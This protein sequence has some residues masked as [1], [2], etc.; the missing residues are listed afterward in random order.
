VRLPC[1]FGTWLDPLF[2]FGSEAIERG[3]AVRNRTGTGSTANGRRG[4]SRRE[5]L[6]S[7]TGAGLS[8]AGANAIAGNEVA[9]ATASPTSKSILRSAMQDGGRIVY[10]T[11][12]GSWEEA[13][14]KAW[15]D[16]FTEQTGIEVVT[17]TGPDYGK[18]R[19]MVEA[20]NTEWDVAEVNPDFQTIGRRENLLETLSP[21]LIPAEDA[22]DPKIL[23]D[24]SVPQVSWA[25]V[26]TYN[27]NAFPT[28][29]HPKDWAEMWDVERFPGKR[30]FDSTVNNGTLEAALL[31]DGVAADQLYP[32]DV[33]RALESLSR[34][35]D[36]II[37]YDTG[38]Q[39]VQYWKDEQAV[40]GVGWDGRVIVAK[41]EGAPIDIE[42]NQSFLTYTV[43]V[44]PKGAPNKALAEQF[45]AYS[46]TPEAQ[47][48]AAIAMP[49]GPL[50]KKAF[51]LIPPERA[52]VLSGGPQMEGKSILVDQ[53]W[54]A[55]NLEQVQEEFTAWRLGG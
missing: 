49:Y 35:R 4:F 52:E 24:T 10:A 5:V 55:D 41:E 11:W 26:L 13:I 48:A 33:P 20:G 54:W 23:D 53:Q 51:D 12:G 36:H 39:Q 22:T 17:V 43:M 42:Y 45:L 2:T 8:L 46:F 18:L 50:N 19:A 38:A 25:L 37:W 47:A 1:V 15:F 3:R 29:E 34:L 44:I 31:A 32:I 21:N 27:T 7:A 9:A 30:A 16:P 6:K 28:G 40:L 14:R